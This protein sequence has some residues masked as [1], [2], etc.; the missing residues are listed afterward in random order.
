MADIPIVIP[1]HNEAEN[2]QPIAAAVS[3]ACPPAHILFVDDN[4]PDGATPPVHEELRR[5]LPGNTLVAAKSRLDFYAEA[6]ADDTALIIATG[7]ERRFANLLL[8]IGVMRK[9]NG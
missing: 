4:S 2:I 3:A 6:K 9:D 5:L 8:T 7:E 1:T